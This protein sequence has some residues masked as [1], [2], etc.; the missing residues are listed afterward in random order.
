MNLTIQHAASAFPRLV[1]FCK[2]F[3]DSPDNLTAVGRQ[4]TGRWRLDRLTCG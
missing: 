2:A 3:T 1:R 4:T